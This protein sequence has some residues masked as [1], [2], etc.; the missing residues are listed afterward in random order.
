MDKRLVLAFAF[1]FAGAGDAAAQCAREG[2]EMCQSGQVYRCE[3]AA[4]EL[5]PIFQNRACT[6]D[7]PLLT[8][9]WRGNGHQ[10]PAGA[11]GADWAIAM[12]ITDGGGSIQYP[13]LNCGG[14]LT[15]LSRDATSAQYRETITYGTGCVT[16]GEITVRYFRGKLAWTWMGSDSNRAINA[17]AVLTR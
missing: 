3:R 5:A 16:G 1:L 8:G 13:S 10:S 14:S 17:I 7:V 4:S 9:T 15:Q 6:V 2:Q 11:Q 12:T